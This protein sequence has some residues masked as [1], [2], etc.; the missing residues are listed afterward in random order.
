MSAASLLFW[1]SGTMLL[2]ASLFALYRIVRG[3]SILDRMIASDMLLT[4]LV[5]VVGVE[6]VYNDHLDTVPL[7]IVL[8]STAIFASISVA[9][10]VSKQDSPR[11]G[12]ERR[13]LGRGPVADAPAAGPEAPPEA[14]NSSPEKGGPL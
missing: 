3:P 2:L 10:Y 6:M 7:M 8:A 11:N 14:G 9:R 5:I 13:A 12:A 4:T 1:F